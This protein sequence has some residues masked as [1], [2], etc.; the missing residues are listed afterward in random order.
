MLHRWLLSIAAAS[1]LAFAQAPAEQGAAPAAARVRGNAPPKKPSAP[2]PRWPDGHPLLS[3]PPG[4]LG[5][6]DAGFGGIVGKGR[7]NLPTNLEISEVPFQPWAKALSAVRRSSQ[8]MSDPHARCVPPGGPR[9]FVTPYGLL[10]YELPEAKRV[11]VLSG[12]GPRTWRVIYTDGRPHPD[13]DDRDPSYFGHSVG[14]WEGDTL[15]VDTV[16]FNEKFWMARG[17]LPH[18]D[19]L[20]LIERISRPDFDT[21]RYEVTID[22]PKAYTKP[23]SGGFNIPWKANEDFPEYFCQENNRDVEHLVGQ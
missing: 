18:T 15:V 7:N 14:H 12:G 17:G 4:Q 20:H 6:W 10:I 2:T 21:L 1:A 23:W 13:A 5:Y 9:Q 3:A 22:D 19:A 11:L 16:G 8:D